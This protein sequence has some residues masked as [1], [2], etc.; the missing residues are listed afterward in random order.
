MVCADPPL[1]GTL[2]T[3]AALYLLRQLPSMALLIL[4]VLA[5]ARLRSRRI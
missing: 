1:D 4:L 2:P 5:F 3:A